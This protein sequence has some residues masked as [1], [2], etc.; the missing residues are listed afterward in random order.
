MEAVLQG[1]AK[2]NRRLTRQPVPEWSP[3]TFSR[4]A[5][6]QFLSE[7]Q[8][9]KDGKRISIPVHLEITAATE[10]YSVIEA[11]LTLKILERAAAPREL[12]HIV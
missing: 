9:F 1:P 4:T 7:K 8:L 2:L 5:L 12:G 11:L 3:L 6:S 10:L